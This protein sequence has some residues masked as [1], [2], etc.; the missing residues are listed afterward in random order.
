MTKIAVVQ[1]CPSNINYEKMYKL[2]GVDIFNLSSTKVSRL[3]VKDVDLKIQDKQT[4]DRIEYHIQDRIHEG[5]D[6][7]EDLGF[8]PENYDWVIL[9]GSEALK[10]F[11]K[12]TAVTDYSG[13]VAPGKKGETNFIASISPAAL[14]FKPET[15]PVFDK[16]VLCIAALVS[17]AEERIFEGDYKFFRETK[18]FKEYLTYLVQS[19]I[20]VIGLDSE[21]TAL[22]CRDGYVLGI[23][24]SH[25]VNQGVYA[26]ADCIDEECIA[27][28][29]EL[30]DTRITVLHNAKFDMHFLTYHFSL[31]FVGRNIEDTMIMHYLLDERQGTHGLKSLTMKYG[32][33]GD[34]DRELDEYRRA[35]CSNNGILIGDFTYDLFPWDIIKI[36]AAKD[37]DATLALYF[38]FRPV[39]EKNQKLLDC[40]NNL[41]LPGLH[42]LTKMEDRGVPISKERL[43]LGKKLLTDELDLLEKELYSFKEIHELESIQ[44]AVFKPGSVKQLRILLFDL[45]GLE[46]TGKLTKTKAIS[47]DAEVLKELGDRH[48]LPGLILEIRQ[49]T[50]LK[51]TYIDKLIPAIDR[52]SRVRTGF[53]ITSTTS[54]R[55]SSSGKFN[56]QQLPRENPI[57]KG[58]VKAPK[59]YK[60]VAV[61]LSTAEVYYAAVLSDDTAMKQIF[62]DMKRDPKKYPDFHS[63]VAHMVF[64]LSCSPAE[65][66]KLY[67]ALRQAAKAITFGI[68]YGSGPASVAESVN[69]AFA[70]EGQPQTCTVD[71]AKG[72]I[73]YYFSKFH[74]LKAWIDRT[75]REIKTMGYVYNF[76]GRKRRLHNVNSIDKGMAA[77][78]VRSGFNAVIQSVSSDHLLLGAIDADKLIDAIGMDA[79]IFALVHDS[80]VAVVKTEEVPAYIDLITSCIQIDRGCSIENCP[81]GVEEDSEPG[82]SED[83]S[84]GKL[85]KMFPELAAA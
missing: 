31:N 13:K 51:N 18:P 20:K 83:Y 82:G 60:I 38:K 24:V 7:H 77:G 55:L 6:S 9:V 34:Y 57:I 70:E 75:H 76:F 15:Q 28:L 56:M 85:N 72:Y 52:D 47:T 29:Q 59:G 26:D 49:K 78:E 71:D 3:L 50:K 17:G 63:S 22:A 16:T 54:G 35:Y 84:C 62:I 10:M 39:L 58:C 80:V 74:K 2:S 41:M 25:K 73:Q 67:P 32:T 64:N 42:F 4:Y 40:Y 21:T 27:L 65:V 66:K 5:V 44:G 37:T 61:D 11:T 53:N 12:A 8:C 1:K 46:P 69:A 30:L 45:L 79:G 68:I 33:L 23:S 48:R 14:T 81:V 43:V 19:A 36:Y